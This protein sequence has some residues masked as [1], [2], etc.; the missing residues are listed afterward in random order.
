MCGIPAIV[1]DELKVS[2]RCQYQGKLQFIVIGILGLV[3]T[4]KGYLVN[5][6]LFFLVQRFL[7]R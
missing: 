2:L 4:M 6:C 5:I 3:D 1:S 7:P